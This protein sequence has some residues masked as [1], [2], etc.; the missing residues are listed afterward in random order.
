M[1]IAIVWAEWRSGELATY[2]VGIGEAESHG[3][4]TLREC[5]QWA[6]TQGAHNMQT[7]AA[8]E[9]QPDGSQRLPVAE[10]ALQLAREELG[11]LSQW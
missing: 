3:N 1:R 4:P 6:M 5:A 7:I 11:R 8:V 10:W 2:A 9:E